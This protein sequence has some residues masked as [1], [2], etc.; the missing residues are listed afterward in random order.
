MTEHWISGSSMGRNS[1]ILKLK[2][3]Q[4]ILRLRRSARRVTIAEF[5]IIFK[6]WRIYRLYQKNEQPLWQ[7]PNWPLWLTEEYRTC[8]IATTRYAF[9][10]SIYCGP[11]CT[12]RNRFRSTSK[13]VACWQDR[14]F[15]R[16]SKL[17]RFG[18]NSGSY[19]RDKAENYILLTCHQFPDWKECCELSSSI[20]RLFYSW[21]LKVFWLEPEFHRNFPW[22]HQ[23]LFANQGRHQWLLLLIGPVLENADHKLYKL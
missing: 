1:Q 13:T 19:P 12:L 17:R 9:S 3:P 6:F 2:K 5:I 15:R 16:L 7:R 8:E 14:T 22:F 10:A 18:L 20:F 23:Y 11:M 4:K 21:F